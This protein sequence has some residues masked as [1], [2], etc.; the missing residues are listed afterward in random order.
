LE[1]VVLRRFHAIP[2]FFLALL[3]FLPCASAG[4]QGA[5]VK[6]V[7]VGDSTVALGGGWGPGFCAMFN[8]AVTCVDDALNGRSS[9]SFLAEGAW[10]KALA[11]KGNY[12]LIQFG[13]NDMKGK[14]A[15]RETDPE[16][17]FASNLERYIADARALGAQPILLTSLSRRTFKDGAIVEDLKEY[18]AATRRVGRDRGVPVIDLNRISTEM[19]S[20]MT[21][22]E[23][24]QFDATGQE[25]ERL[26]VGQK[27]DRP[28]PPES[29][30][31]E[32]LRPHCG[33]RTRSP[34]TRAWPVRA[35]AATRKQLSRASRMKLSS[36]NIAG[37]GWHV[38]REMHAEEHLIIAR[39]PSTRRLLQLFHH[40]ARK[41][42]I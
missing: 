8:P 37:V 6:I 2:I 39:H 16:T 27:R 15:D 33:E 23:A 34:A 25:K 17:T 21:Q 35:S 18:A 13:H 36:Q 41:A 19:L 20:H 42:G 14:G 22:A 1:D 29:A 3:L 9:K 10:T 31:A 40:R 11:V 32:D 30:G 12:Y 38:V 24:D 26:A 7:L 4:T 28:D 5:A